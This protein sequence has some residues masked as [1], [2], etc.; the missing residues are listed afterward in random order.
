[1]AFS[2][3]ALPYDYTALEPSIDS[4]TMNIVS[5]SRRGCFLAPL[6]RLQH[7][8]CGVGVC[9]GTSALLPLPQHHTKHHQTYVNN[10]N[11]AVEKFPEFAVG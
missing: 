11:A 2:L 3:P 8:V 10:L 6:A 1:M 5:G 7:W 9:S 4:M